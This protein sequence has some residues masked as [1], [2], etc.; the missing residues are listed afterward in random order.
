MLEGAT[1]LSIVP[2]T[3]M[4]CILWPF[5]KTLWGAMVN[6]FLTGSTAGSLQCL[7]LAFYTYPQRPAG[8]EFWWIVPFACFVVGHF[9]YYMHGRTDIDFP[10]SV[11]SARWVLYGA[12]WSAVYFLISRRP[13]MSYGLPETSAEY[14]LCEDCETAYNTSRPHT[15][16]AKAN[17]PSSKS[18]RRSVFYFSFLYC[19]LSF[20]ALADIFPGHFFEA[21]AEAMTIIGFIA[22]LCHM[23]RQITEYDDLCLLFYVFAVTNAVYDLVVIAKLGAAINP[24]VGSLLVSFFGWLFMNVMYHCA[25]RVTTARD[26]LLFLFPARF[27]IDLTQALFFTGDSVSPDTFEFWGLLLLQEGSSLAFNTGFKH[28]L[29]F[30]LN[31]FADVATVKDNP[32]RDPAQFAEIRDRA[33]IDT[34]SEQFSVVVIATAVLGGYIAEL[35]GAVGVGVKCPWFPLADTGAVL[36][37]FLIVVGVRVVTFVIEELVLHRLEKR[38]SSLPP[39]IFHKGWVWLASVL[40]LANTFQVL[41]ATND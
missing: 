24:L 11:F 6:G 38:F 39:F 29:V 8:H 25:S 21:I 26:A 1:F 14:G 12:M 28:W 3:L 10:T 13:F 16:L 33:R 30:R 41:T 2:L 17:P 23:R 35:L 19:L 32:L 20:Y 27:G 37:R 7:A 15:C 9:I 5:Y 22:A 31:L 36:L 40:C 18:V 4:L 34:V